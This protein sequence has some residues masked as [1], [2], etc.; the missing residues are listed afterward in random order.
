M[1]AA[2]ITYPLG[3]LLRNSV[4]RGAATHFSRRGEDAPGAASFNLSELDDRAE[5]HTGLWHA[6]GLGEGSRVGMIATPEPETVAAIVGALRAGVEVVLLSP[7]LESPEIA[8]NA[9]LARAP[10]L[11]GP[12]EFAGIDYAK[13]LAEARAAS[14]AVAWLMVWEKDRPRLFRL[15]NAQPN[16]TTVAPDQSEAGLAVA[17][18]AKVRALDGLRLSSL[19]AQLAHALEIQ[20][21]ASIVSLVSPATPG[22]LIASVYMPLFASAHL[23]WQSPFSALLLDQTLREMAPA[24]L[25]APAAAA[26]ALG[27]AQLLSPEF[28]ASLTLIVSDDSPTPIFETDLE[29]E[30]VFFLD[31]WLASTRPLT[32]LAEDLGESDDG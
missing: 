2:R 11:A 7:S 30:R 14:G 29:A 6:A 27:E 23:V 5:R 20:Q 24:H 12:A 18:D 9:S 28:L 8:A 16:E 26:A 21:G 31:A 32:R 13:R 4:E 17:H 3:R 15:D 25:V 19:A 1:K 22:G 10:A